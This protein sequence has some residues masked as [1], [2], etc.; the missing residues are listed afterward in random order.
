MLIL[1]RMLLCII[2]LDD[3]TVQTMVMIVVM[4]IGRCFSSKQLN[5]CWVVTHLVGVPVT[6]NMLV[7]ADYLVGGRHY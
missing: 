7:Q 5:K 1:L 2:W 3:V 6:A 4:C